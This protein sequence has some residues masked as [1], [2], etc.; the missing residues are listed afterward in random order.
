MTGVITESFREQLYH[1][2]LIMVVDL[3]G[4]VMYYEDY[5]DNINMLKRENAVGHSIFELYPFFQRQDFTIFKAMDLKKPILNEYQSFTV[6]GQS[7]QAVNSAYPL[8]NETGVVGGIVISTELPRRSGERRRAP[9]RASY[10]FNDI[11]TWDPAFLQGLATLRRIAANDSTLLI[12]GE[13]GTGKELI[14]HSM[15]GASR[16]G[17]GPFIIQNC[18]AIPSSIMESILF[19]TTKGSFTG[20]IDKEGLFEAAQGGTIFLDEINSLALDLQSK[21]LRVLE[22]RAVRRVGETFEREVDVRVIASSN[23]DLLK[24]VEMG[25]FRGDLYYRLNVFTF[26]VPPLRRRPADVPGLAEHFAAQFASLQGKRLAGLSRRCTPCWPPPPG[27]A[28][29][30]S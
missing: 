6:D 1:S 8:I 29:P 25:E 30:A 3:H 18:A 19:G 11:L 4:K 5:N 2:N 22:S 9:L 14:A 7:R 28:T 15:H 26:T 12:L 17:K 23:E 16:R 20:A 24:K 13:T 21:L 27:R 10:S